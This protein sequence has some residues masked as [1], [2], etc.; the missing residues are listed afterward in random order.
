MVLVIK[1]K[2]LSS[3]LSQQDVYQSIIIIIIIIIIIV[4]VVVVIVIVIV[5]IISS[6][7]RFT[8]ASKVVYTGRF[9]PVCAGLPQLNEAP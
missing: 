9:G 5:N 7:K 2:Y 6:S 8:R 1:R 3:I 4:V